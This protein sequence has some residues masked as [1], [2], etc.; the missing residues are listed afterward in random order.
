MK[1]LAI[2][3]AMAACSVAVIDS[4]LPQPLA[5]DFAAMER[6]HAEAVAPM[7]ERA[8]AEAG[9]TFSELQRIAVTT[10]PG[11]FTGVRIG[12]SLARGFGVAL[13]IPVVGVDSLTA[14]ARNLREGPLLAAADA[15]KGEVYAAL[16]DA[17]L[18]CVRP[19]AVKALADAA[20]GLP[21]GA[22]VIGT[23]A[24][25]VIAAS[26]RSDLVRAT[27]G[28]LPVAANF[29]QYAAG[30]PQPIAP[31]SPLYLRSP[32]AKPQAGFKYRDAALSFTA[33]ASAE[34]LAQIHGECFDKPWPSPEMAKLMAMPGSLTLTALLGDEPVAFVLARTAADEAEIIVIATRPFA[35]RRG[36][37][38]KLLTDLSQQLAQKGIGSLFLEVAAGNMAARKLY[39]ACGFQAVA[40]RDKYY[41]NGGDALVMRRNLVP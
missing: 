5:Q 39:E 11:T 41:T 1:L 7:V 3:T 8:M 14:I 20:R 25:M 22:A 2:D 30:L 12:L 38:R 6:G 33:S 13:N 21:A 28:D 40:T 23:A 16:F 32:D 31:P 9:I 24:D 4:A 18:Q 35:Q 29:A 37:A 34:I 15:R 19:P 10:G 17:E 36:I 26:D 27:A